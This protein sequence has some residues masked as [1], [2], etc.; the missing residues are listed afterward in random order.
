MMDLQDY[1]ARTRKLVEAD[2]KARVPRATT[3]PATLHRAMRH[4]LFAG[5]K[6]LRPILCVA[7][8][9]ASLA[10]YCDKL[11]FEKGWDHGDEKLIIAQA[12]DDEV[13]SA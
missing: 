5:G 7:D 10:Y 9:E 6:R 2:L 3:R 4:S 8:V 1:V 11:G 13:R 12:E